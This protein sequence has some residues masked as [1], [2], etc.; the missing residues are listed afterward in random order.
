[1]TKRSTTLLLRWALAFVFFYAAIASLLNPHEWIGYLPI[2]LTRL[3]PPS[4]LLSAFSVYQIVLTVWLFSG[5]R[6]ASAAALAFFT[7]LAI[8]VSNFGLLDI[9]FG[10]IGLAITALALF[11]LGRQKKEP[12]NL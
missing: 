10:D 1:M 11:D 5:R 2:F 9:L 6:V 12:V 7:L 8:I 4:W 3:V